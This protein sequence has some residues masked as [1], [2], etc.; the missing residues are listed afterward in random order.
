LASPGRSGLAGGHGGARQDPRLGVTV[1]ARLDDAAMDR[2]IR[3]VVGHFDVF[4]DRL[5]DEL[6]GERRA[7]YE[8]LIAAAPRLHKRY[9]D[10]KKA[11]IAADACCPVMK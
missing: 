9:R 6:S 1:G 4:A 2:F 7:F 8:R 11:I 10:A 3:Q 5:G